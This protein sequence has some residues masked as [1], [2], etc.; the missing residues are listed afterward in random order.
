MQ[1]WGQKAPSKQQSDGK[2]RHHSDKREKSHGGGKCH[3]NGKVVAEN[4]TK[5]IK[6]WQKV[7]LLFKSGGTSTTISVIV[8]VH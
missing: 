8:V 2:K 5:T 7:P 4:A 3:Q 1:K 6:L